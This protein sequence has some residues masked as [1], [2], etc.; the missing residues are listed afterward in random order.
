MLRLHNNM[1]DYLSCFVF[2]SLTVTQKLSQWSRKR[3]LWS[4]PGSPSTSTRRSRTTTSSPLRTLKSPVC[5]GLRTAGERWI[6]VHWRSVLCGPPPRPS[7]QRCAHVET[8][9]R[10]AWRERL[11]W[12]YVYGTNQTLDCLRF[13]V[14]LK[15]IFYTCQW[16]RIYR[17]GLAGAEFRPLSWSDSIPS[18]VPSTSSPALGFYTFPPHLVLPH[19]L[20]V[21]HTWYMK[22]K[23]TCSAAY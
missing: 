7:F 17:T 18:M 23:L 1:T 16:P 5:A 19:K 22:H 13:M 14:L 4:T 11:V 9:L 8:R 15:L 20:Y 10:R 6:R 21:H 3:R 2:F 12:N